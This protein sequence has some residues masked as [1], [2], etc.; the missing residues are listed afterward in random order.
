M[1]TFFEWFRD[2]AIDETE[3]W[4]ILG[5]GP[6]FA[7]RHDYDLSAFH[8]L[9]LNHAVREQP[10]KVAHIIDFEVI[11]QCAEAIRNNAGILVVPWR[12][13]VNFLPSAKHLG[14][15]LST[16]QTLRALDEQGRLLCYNLST[17]QETLEGSPVVTAE[18]FSA[19][20]GLD[21]LAQAGVRSIRSLGID[22]GKTYSA[23]FNDLKETTLLACG[24]SSF[25]KQFKGFA[26]T[27]LATGVDYAPLDIQA[28]IRIYVGATEAETLPCKVLEYSIRKHASMSVE[29]FPLCH[30]QIDIPQPKQPKNQPRTPFSFQRFLIPALT[31]YQ[32][33]AIYLD[34]DMLLF[35]DIRN[36]WSVPFHGADL[37]AVHQSDVSQPQFSVMLLNCDSLSWDIKEIVRELDRG[38][39]SYEQLMFEMAV[40]TNVRAAIEPRWNSLE[41]FAEEE[42]ALLHY[43]DMNTQPWRSTGN[44]LGYLWMQ[45]LFEALDSGHILLAEIEDHVR[46]GYLRPSLLYQIEQRI[47]DSRNLDQHA[48]ELDRGFVPPNVVPQ[49]RAGL[50]RRTAQKV[51]NLISHPQHR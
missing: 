23:E 43:T 41:H 1:Q 44:G 12:P 35:D 33:R 47:P 20:A 26:R 3:P 31:N 21:L 48:V 34:S 6:S 24:H 39:L 13:H 50:A 16:S 14:E 11:E 40:A 17:A 28:P 51:V 36:L 8:L 30:A 22:G 45:T 25:D 4:L 37:L 9:S 38:A 10:V 46:R 19:E 49:P 42:T 5:K 27:I 2:Q 32:G 18:F 7:R 29:V 15:L